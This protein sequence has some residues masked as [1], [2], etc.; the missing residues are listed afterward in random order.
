MP[1]QW[2]PGVLA[3]VNPLICLC[4][5]IYRTVSDLESD[6]L[7]HSNF[8]IFPVFKHL[9]KLVALLSS[10][11]AGPES[12]WISKLF[13]HVFNRSP[14]ESSQ[15]DLLPLQISTSVVR[16]IDGKKLA[17][18]SPE[19]DLREWK[20]AQL[21]SGRFIVS[22]SH[23]RLGKHTRSVPRLED[24]TLEG[25]LQRRQALAKDRN[26]RGSVKST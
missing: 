14:T 20:T 4:M 24:I 1:V 17:L 16:A 22:D 10:P 7:H 13:N 15:A 23:F 6:S 11:L 26:S 3:S 18:R 8:I 5:H 12:M 21:S 25:V 19:V 2:F 9:F